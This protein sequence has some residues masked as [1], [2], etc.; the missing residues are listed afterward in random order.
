MRAADDGPPKRDRSEL[1][2]YL[3]A[4]A[5]LLGLL[6]VV[7]GDLLLRRGLD[8][9]SHAQ[10]DTARWYV[11]M[12]LFGYSEI[13][14]GHIPLWNPFTF[15]GMPFV[16][17]FQS[18]LFYPPN[19]LYLLVGL[20]HGIV[21]EFVVTLFTLGML[22]FTWIRRKGLRAPSAFVAAVV[23]MFGST[24]TLRVLAGQFSVL[25]TFA[26][27]PLLLCAVDSLE[28]RFSLGWL[29]AGI[30]AVTLMILAGHPPTVLQA[31]IATGLYVLPMWLRSPRRMA[32]LGSLV[33]LAIA[34]I[35]L[36]AIQ[37][38]EGLSTAGEALRSQGMSYEFAVSYSFPPE[39]LLTL[40]GPDLFGNA[41]RFNLTYFG[42][43]FYWDSTYFIGVCA[44]LLALHG[45]GSPDRVA[46]RTAL[47]L[48]ALLCVVAMGGYT[49]L[50]WILYE[51]VPGFDLMR[52]PSKFL[53]FSS[54]FA[55]W[56]VALGSDRLLEGPRG[57]GRAAALALGLAALAAGLHAW[58]LWS[59]VSLDEGHGPM[60]FFMSLAR[61]REY[62][63][64]GKAV[65]WYE[66][67]LIGSALAGAIALAAA[68]L[69]GLARRDRRAA[70]ALIGLAILELLIFA[71]IGRG[72]TRLTIDADLRPQ[73][74]EAY[75]I[76]GRSRVHE[77][78]SNSNVAV[79]RRRYGIYGYDPVVLRRYIE[80]MMWSQGM[81][82]R[83]KRNS[84]RFIAREHHRLHAMLRVRHLID[85][86]NKQ[87][88]E[89]DD[90]MPQFAFVDEYRVVPS[91]SVLDVMEDPGFDPRTSAILESEPVPA[92]SRRAPGVARPK[93]WL[94]GESTDHFDLELEVASPTLLLITDAWSRGWRARPLDGSDQTEYRLQPA[95]Y[96]LRAV[97]LAPGHH[98]MRVEYAPAAYTAGLWLT[99]VSGVA[100][101]A[102][103]GVWLRRRWRA[104]I[105]KGNRSDRP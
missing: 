66:R 51:Y 24:V 1:L 58:T 96:V 21:L 81:D 55:A 47:W 35:G 71:R 6:L 14:A 82:W 101:L 8:I 98:R 30:A 17:T 90:A 87:L 20:R 64:D 69:L 57:L 88:I 59:P 10:G 84:S 33:P 54:V 28:R 36:A 83:D 79:G 105:A 41:D 11:F 68:G 56:L 80:F 29:L 52:A 53:F 89:F 40:L 31:G 70:Y 13:A 60:S 48:G 74:N 7:F 78:A 85:W 76:S 104:P 39:N 49:P 62:V 67:L 92:P 61:N 93:L 75:A 32:L 46:R 50:Y 26:W 44:L 2:A 4:A 23:V 99:S 63:V 45:L 86:H 12:R 73:A 15:S 103:L 38:F 19:L 94:L 72:T 9:P 91:D 5:A 34:P 97:P 27:W 43:V 102:A 65:S 18:S 37:L 22:T 3:Y 100:Y 95:N 42:R 25:E 77:T 16:G